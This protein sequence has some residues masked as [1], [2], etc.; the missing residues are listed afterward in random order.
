MRLRV[1]YVYRIISAFAARL[2]RLGNTD[3]IET[4]MKFILL[5]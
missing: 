1:G 2:T 4:V 5:R 3:K